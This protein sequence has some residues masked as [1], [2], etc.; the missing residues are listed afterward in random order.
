MDFV[1]F[2]S[3]P[4]IKLIHGFRSFF[5]VKEPGGEI[6]SASPDKQASKHTQ[7]LAEIKEGLKDG[8]EIRREKQKLI[9]YL[10]FSILNNVFF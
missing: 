4:L 2:L 7:I 3:E 10:T 6:F 1:D 8:K 9:L 5:I